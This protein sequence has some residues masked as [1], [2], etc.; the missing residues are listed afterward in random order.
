MAPE[1]EIV[2]ERPSESDST[3]DLGVAKFDGSFASGVRPGQ[4]PSLPWYQTRE[5]VTAGW[6]DFSIWKAAVCSNLLS[7]HL[8]QD[9]LCSIDGLHSL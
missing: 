5:Y 2:Q 6:T 4:P 8:W 7:K 1:S 3:A 9:D